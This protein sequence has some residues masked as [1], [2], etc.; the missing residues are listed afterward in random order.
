MLTLEKLFPSV[1]INGLISFALSFSLTL[2][3]VQNVSGQDQKAADSLALIY[4]ADTVQGL[5]K[6]E[7]LAESVITIC[8]TENWI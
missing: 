3:V 4:Q 8:L 6:L 1:S 5:E 7:L 2:L